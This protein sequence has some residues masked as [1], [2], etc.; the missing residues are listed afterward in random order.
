[1]KNGNNCTVVQNY[2]KLQCNLKTN[3]KKNISN[4]IKYFCTAVNSENSTLVVV[5]LFFREGQSQDSEVVLR[6]AHLCT[7]SQSSVMSQCVSLF[8]SFPEV[9][10]LESRQRPSL[11]T[12]LIASY[13][14]KEQHKLL[15]TTQTSDR[16]S[17]EKEILKKHCSCFALFFLKEC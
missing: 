5:S 9:S 12:E 11:I 8:S 14:H 15:S 4:I 13:I 3:K 2:L 10:M 6:V 7:V 1:M 16:S 17:I